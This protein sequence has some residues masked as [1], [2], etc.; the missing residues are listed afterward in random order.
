MSVLLP[1]PVYDDVRALLER[2]VLEI[3]TCDHAAN[4]CSCGERRVLAD[5][6]IAA[7]PTS[8]FAPL[9]RIEDVDADRSG[10]GSAIATR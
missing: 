1:Q 5:L 7:L 8:D 9:P 10:N 4:I 3:G 6:E 2:Y